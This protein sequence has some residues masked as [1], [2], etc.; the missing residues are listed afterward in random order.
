MPDL[1][2]INSLTKPNFR[3]FLPLKLAPTRHNR[4]IFLMNEENLGKIL[5]KM[6][7]A[8]S[9]LLSAGAKS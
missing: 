6:I 5:L 9:V 3:H 7:A 1:F 8:K 4:A 2:S